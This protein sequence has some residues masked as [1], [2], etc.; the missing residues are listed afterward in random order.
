MSDMSD[1]IWRDDTEK[2][3]LEALVSFPRFDEA[4]ARA[5]TAI[6]AVSPAP[7]DF[8]GPT[9]QAIDA[10][11]LK[12]FATNAPADREAYF[13]AT[14]EWFQDRYSRYFRPAPDALATV[15]AG[16]DALLA[17]LKLAVAGWADHLE[18]GDPVPDW[19]PVAQ[20][21]IR[22]TTGGAA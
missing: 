20:T 12:A 15:T 22:R 16:R 7:C 13:A 11:R 21:A 18:D 8:D 3:V 2:A 6:R 10:M 9:E 5:V 17:A 14:S 4:R 19:V 1:L